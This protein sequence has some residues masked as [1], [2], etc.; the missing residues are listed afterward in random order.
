MTDFLITRCKRFST[1]DC[2]WK[3][4]ARFFDYR[5]F[6]GEKKANTSHYKFENEKYY[7][8]FSGLLFD[9][10]LLFKKYNGSCKFLK[11]YCK[12]GF[13]YLSEISGSFSG[14]VFDKHDKELFV[15]SD[16][17]GTKPVYYGGDEKR[18]VASNSFSMLREFNR[19]ADAGLLEISNRGAYSLLSYG[20]SLA[21]ETIYKNLN[22]IY[23]GCLLKI[24]NSTV[25]ECVFY[26]LSNKPD[27]SISREDAIEV[28]DE[29]FCA[30]I[31]QQFEHDIS[32]GK[33]HLVGLSGGLDSRMVSMVAHKRGYMDQT[34]FTFS[35]SDYLDETIAKKIAADLGHDWI[36]KALD[37]GSF[38]KH[39]DE[40][41]SFSGGNVLVFGLAH[42]HSFYRLLDFDSFGLLHTGQLGDVV[43]GTYYN[44]RNFSKNISKGDG[45]FSDEFS[46]H[47]ELDTDL[48][49]NQEIFNF[50][51][52]GFSGINK[53]LLPINQRT[54]TFSPF[55]NREFLENSLKIPP[56]L[57]FGHSLYKDWIMTKHP[58]S[59][60]YIWEKTGS[61]L[62]TRTY[63]FKNK[64]YTLKQWINIFLYKMAGV[65]FRGMHTKNHMNPI[66][67]WLSEK[68]YLSEFVGNY[69]N[70]NIHL[71]RDENLKND[72]SRL[73]HDYGGIE[74]I[75]VLSL[76][77]SFRA[78]DN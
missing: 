55:Y 38:L 75:Q 63:S 72:V 70:E 33:K 36:F 28:I 56:E 11:M 39:V 14:F 19:Y 37:N 5:V 41:T 13:E 44:D 30:A 9:G 23:P 51:N 40:V 68:K 57:R 74:K 66:D 18:F 1:V 8:F 76:L 21:G 77:S 78:I 24:R 26:K 67:Y 60:A 58:E 22:I 12:Y 73:F 48:Y 54:E 15:F 62:S 7:V 52:R 25:S 64:S 32:L 3:E 69:Y 71:V 27:Y 31:D 35:Q 53:G 4:T 61:S 43:L 42:G 6:I 47:I 65:Q 50:Y 29:Y 46:H 20:Y 10:E 59:A 16:F 34:N 49:P 17:I 2:F 45:A